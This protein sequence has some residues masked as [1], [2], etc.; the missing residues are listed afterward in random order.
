MG[1]YQQA[2]ELAVAAAGHNAEWTAKTASADYTGAPSSASSGVGIDA[3]KTLLWVEL[4]D[5]VHARTGYITLTYDAAITT[6]DVT[7]DGNLVSTA[8]NTDTPTTLVDLA[9]DIT[10][11]TPAGAGDVVTATAVDTD[12]DS[13]IDAVKIVGKA[14]ADY[15]LVLGITGGP[16]AGTLTATIDAAS[17][18]LRV[19]G[20]AGGQ[21]SNRPDGWTLLEGGTYASLTYRGFNERFDTASYSRIYGEL[22]TVAG[23]GAPETG[24]SL[25]YTASVTYGPTDVG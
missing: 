10:A 21:A 1:T 13:V 8:P 6:Y 23:P 4:R 16:G 25:T 17:A 9:A 7:I 24:T 2:N 22:Y 14:E 5:T 20:K 15:T 19:F 12:G 3:L 18:N 11:D